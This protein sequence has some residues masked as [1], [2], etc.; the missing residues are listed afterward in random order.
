M[1]EVVIVGVGMHP[2]G[3]FPGESYIAMG[4]EAVKG[5]L[6][7]GNVPWK[8]VQAAFCS[9]FF[10]PAT[11]GAAILQELGSIGIPICDVENACA[12][13]T[14]ALK[15]AY[16][17]VAFGICDVAL[18]F[19]VE[20]MGKGLPDQTKNSQYQPWMLTTGLSQNV[21][22][23]AVHAQRHMHE[24]GTTLQQ[25][26]K[27]VVKNHKFGSLNPNAFYRKENTVEEVLNSPMFSE[28]L[29]RYM[30]C[31]LCSGAAAV[32][33]CSREKASKYAG[34][35]FVTLAAS[36]TGTGTF[37]TDFSAGTYQISARGKPVSATTRV[38]KQAYEA[39]GLGPEDIDIVEL[40][41]VD[42]FQEIY[43]SEDLGLF[44]PGEG[45]PA[46]ER[47]D[48]GIGGKVVISPSGGLLSNG[49][50]M[51]ASHLRQIV[52]HTWQLRG[53]AGTRQVP[54]AKVAL[55]HVNGGLFNCGVSIL[56]R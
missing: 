12:S 37:P 27:V 33:L 46:A 52:E 4:L 51:G 50:A 19:G 15:L 42:A 3:R 47:G 20:E 30:L 11:T 13:G 2:M 53:Q 35:P 54:N 16:Q 49:E 36:V 9:T 48:T 18:A 14:S 44:K 45:G 7:D 25:A 24:H 1:R 31:T 43:W 34:R 55:A 38:S 6:K 5:A 39:A 10:L 56:K 29:T 23:F 21:V 32:V 22:A 17:Q 40:Q 26:A 28:P 41:D 8:D